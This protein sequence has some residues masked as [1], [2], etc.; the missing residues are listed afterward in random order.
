MLSGCIMHPTPPASPCAPTATAKA[1]AWCSSPSSCAAPRARARARRPS[2]SPR[3]HGLREPARRDHG[4][5]RPRASRSSSSTATRSTRSTSS[6]IDVP[7]VRTEALSRDE[8]EHRIKTRLGRKI[9]VV[10]ACTGSDAHTVGIDA[11]LNYKGYAGDKGL[12]SYKGFEVYNLGAQ[13]ENDQLA[14]RARA[15]EGRRD[16]R[17][18]GHH[19]AQ[20]PQGERARARRA[21]RAAGLAR[22]TSSCSSA[23]RASTTS[24]RSSSGFDAGFGPGTKPGDVA[25][26]PGRPALRPGRR[27]GKRGHGED[28]HPVGGNAFRGR[29]ERVSGARRRRFRSGRA[30]LPRGRTRWPAKGDAIASMANGFPVEGNAFP[31]SGNGIA[32]RGNA[33]A[34]RSNASPRRGKRVSLAGDGASLR[35]EVAF[36][37]GGAHL[38]AA[39]AGLPVA[40]APLARRTTPFPRRRNAFPRDAPGHAAPLTRPGRPEAASAHNE[41][42][43][44][45]DEVL[46][47]RVARA[48]VVAGA[49]RGRDRVDAPRPGVDGGLHR[50]VGHGSADA[51]YI[52]EP[53]P[54]D[55]EFGFQVQDDLRLRRPTL[56]APERPRRRG[57]KGK[58][59]KS[60]GK[61]GGG[62][63]NPV[64]K[65]DPPANTPL[66]PLD[67]PNLPFPSRSRG[68][69][70][71][72]SRG[73]AGPGSAARRLASPA[74]AGTPAS[75]RAARTRRGCA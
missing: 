56:R 42:R 31:A 19:A 49:A 43:A 45:L 9:V 68:P 33:S 32:T 65:Q 34:T 57:E 62:P 67:L 70:A 63:R 52:R 17:Q 64:R 50:L 22:A 53:H 10:G 60:Q 72:Q 13:V 26:L 38:R 2:A 1:T 74:P 18:P 39:E 21:A 54:T 35:G 41:R 47:G 44:A 61:R 40:E 36:P 27:V 23:A 28:E 14:A 48:A 30:R 73:S 59:G 7:E 3:L 75:P 16:P 66:S 29:R 5:V 12:E 69:E 8:I 24:S 4:V 15:L 25:S 71:R 51:A 20:L 6:T 37:R 46:D 58:S 11:I 55:N